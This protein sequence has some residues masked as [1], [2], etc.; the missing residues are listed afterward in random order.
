VQS[1]RRLLRDTL[2]ACLAVRPDITVVGKVAEPDA[3]FEL[4]ELRHPDVVIMDAGARLREISARVEALVKRYPELN[5]IVTYRDASEQDLAAACR[6]GVTSL[7]PES[8]GLSAVLALLRRSRGRHA[9]DSPGGLTDRELELVVLTGS[10]HS[11]A[12]IANLLGISPLTVENLKRRVYAKLDVSSSVHAVAK[13]ASLGML[14]PQAPPEAAKRRPPVPRRRPPAEGDG[15]VLAVVSGQYCSALDQVVSALVSSPLPF[16][17]VREPGPVSDTHW[18]RWHRGPIVA[19]LVDPVPQD[20][21]MVAE[22]GVPAILVHSKPLDPPE[23]A[24]ALACGAS[25]LVSADRI[26][27]HFL[28]VLRMVGQGYLVVDSMPMRPLIGA[29]RARWD[30]RAPG[31]LELPELTARESDILRSLSRGHSI[32]Q[33]ARVLGIAPKTVENV[34]TRLF[35]KLGVRNRSGALAVADAF[36]LLPGA[37]PAPGAPKGFPSPE[38]YPSLSGSDWRP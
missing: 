16:V 23:L 37:T 18:A 25:S 14:E 36:G 13:A 4:C 20:W 32:R 11:V 26:E 21:D 1:S 22:L 2:S 27:D 10:G 15:V 29:V 35:R 34:Q 24:E 5:V 7:V 3:I 30:E 17:L 6:A 12:E 8:K 38:G 33:T 28:S 19:V 31:R 9:K